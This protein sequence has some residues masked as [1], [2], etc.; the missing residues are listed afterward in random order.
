MLR[1]ER[2]AVRCC[3][4]PTRIFGW[5]ILPAGL[6]HGDEIKV[7]T[8]PPLAATPDNTPLPV[9]ET[10]RLKRYGK[11]NTWE[12]AVYSDDRPIDFWRQVP[13]FIESTEGTR[14]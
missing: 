6:D 5:M 14:T 7:L 13:G 12:V 10:I 8:L 3:C 1:Q 11:A 2:Y 9:T 4:Q